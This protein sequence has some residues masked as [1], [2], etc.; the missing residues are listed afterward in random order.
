MVEK[1]MIGTT[2]LPATAYTP[3]QVEEWHRVNTWLREQGADWFDA[4]F[5]FAAAL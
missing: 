1:A 4:V 5:D 3:S 2:I